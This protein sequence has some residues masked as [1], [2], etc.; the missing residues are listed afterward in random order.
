MRVTHFENNQQ[1]RKELKPTLQEKTPGRLQVCVFI[2]AA[3]LTKPCLR[4]YSQFVNFRGVYWIIYS[5]SLVMSVS[6]NEPFWRN[7]FWAFQRHPAHASSARWSHLF[8][9]TV[10][11]NRFSKNNTLNPLVDT[12]FQAS[13]CLHDLPFSLFV[14][15]GKKIYISQML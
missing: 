6:P 13:S 15:T 2:L 5:I 10:I 9:R 1:R 8:F 12:P 7:S 11:S 14:G 4:F 3:I